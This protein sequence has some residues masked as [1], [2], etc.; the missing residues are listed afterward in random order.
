MEAKPI[1]PPGT[2]QVVRDEVRRRLEGLVP[3]GGFAFSV[4]QSVQ[5]VVPPE[6]IVAMWETLQE[7]VVY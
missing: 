4:V 1:L 5:A 6:N 3:G 7:S 2:E